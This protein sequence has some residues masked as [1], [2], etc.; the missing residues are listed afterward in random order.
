MQNARTVPAPHEADATSG[1]R[2]CTK[3][4]AGCRERQQSTTNNTRGEWIA[5]RLR[6]SKWLLQGA[7]AWIEPRELR[8]QAE[9]PERR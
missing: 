4:H 7:D 6:L 1:E 8:F 9:M 5:E 2:V 3:R